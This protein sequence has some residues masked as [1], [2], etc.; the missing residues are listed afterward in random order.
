M[1]LGMPPKMKN[2]QRVVTGSA[3]RDI[4]VSP[5]GKLVAVAAARCGDCRVRVYRSEDA[6]VLGEFAAST[7]GA[8]GVAFGPQSRFLYCLVESRKRYLC[9]KRIDLDGGGNCELADDFPEGLTEEIIPDPRGRHLAIRG[10]K[11]LEVFTIPD[12]KLLRRFDGRNN[13]GAA[14][15][16]KGPCIYLNGHMRGMVT[17][18]ELSMGGKEMDRWLSPSTWGHMTISP[19]GRYLLPTDSRWGRA[20]LFDLV[21]GKRVI[22]TRNRRRSFDDRRRWGACAFTPTGRTA[23]FGWDEPLVLSLPSLQAVW[24]EKIA[25]CRDWADLSA[26]ALHKSL[27]AFGFLRTGEVCWF[28]VEEKGGA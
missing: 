2:L 15:D 18:R 21:S 20:F 1:E 5:D 4:D 26:S 16:P 27:V 28:E 17:K 8:Q 7:W 24:G 19:T 12:G 13:I 25:E 22:K 6:S 14:F 3:I 9:L 23:L 11:K 10:N